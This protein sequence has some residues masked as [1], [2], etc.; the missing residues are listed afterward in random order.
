MRERSRTVPIQNK[1]QEIAHERFSKQESLQTPRLLKHLPLKSKKLDKE[2]WP[3]WKKALV[4]GVIAASI[5]IWAK[6]V[7]IQSNTC[8]KLSDAGLCWQRNRDF[9]EL[10][11]FTFEGMDEGRLQRI[12]ILM[13]ENIDQLQIHYAKNLA[14]ADEVLPNGRLSLQDMASRV[15]DSIAAINGGYFHYLPPFPWYYEWDGERYVEGDPVG[16]LVIDQQVIGKNPQKKYWGALRIDLS[17]NPSIVDTNDDVLDGEKIRYSIGSSPILIKNGVSITREAFESRNQR[18]NVVATP[19]DFSFQAYEIMPRTGVCLNK[20]KEL[21]FVVAEGRQEKA[22]GYNL[23][24]FAKLLK[25]LGC[26]D[27]L[28]LDGGGSADLTTRNRNGKFE[29][30]ISPSDGK[31]RPIA[32]A[33]VVTKKL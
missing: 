3:L 28:N 20:K 25:S 27:A 7:F 24:E 19:G 32:T 14:E 12:E 22:R 10:E 17:G 2:G 11:H 9:S 16:E 8:E 1:V 26:E 13:L 5:S 33:F 6:Y 31:K 4:V 21:F 18:E 30:T 15:P 29:S 23:L